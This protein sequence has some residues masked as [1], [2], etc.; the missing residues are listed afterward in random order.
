MIYFGSSNN[1]NDDKGQLILSIV[2]LV[3]LGLFI[4]WLIF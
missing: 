4:K 2:I 1:K 3:V